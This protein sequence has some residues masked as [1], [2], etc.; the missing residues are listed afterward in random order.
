MIVPLLRALYYSFMTFISLLLAVLSLVFKL[1]RPAQYDFPTPTQENMCFASVLVTSLNVRSGPDISYP[2]ITTL[3]S[4]EIVRAYTL[5][6][7]ADDVWLELDRGYAAARYRNQ[8]Y[9]TYPD[10]PACHLPVITYRTSP[11]SHAIPR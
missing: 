7:N 9:L 5:V 1:E 10:V 6:R 2:V 4:D 3:K 8:I 11:D